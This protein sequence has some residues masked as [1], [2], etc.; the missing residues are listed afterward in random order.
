[1]P[2]LQTPFKV[3]IYCTKNNRKYALHTYINS[4]CGR[5]E[6][7]IIG[8][9]RSGKDVVDVNSH[10]SAH[11]YNAYLAEGKVIG[12]FVCDKIYFRNCEIHDFD[13]I[14]L[15]ELSELSC[16]SEDELL[17]YADKGNLY[18][19][20]ISD[21]VI[22]DKPRE[23]SEFQQCHKCKH[24]C[25]RTSQNVELCQYH[26]LKRPPMSWCYIESMVT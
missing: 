20:H 18:G 11:R 16:V 7:G 22:Y 5:K 2:N 21:L 14:T 25:V 12:E 23:L 10:L 17:R 24:N 26:R 4:G 6:F 15:E 1:M 19:W 8:H 13:S 3:Y 9:W